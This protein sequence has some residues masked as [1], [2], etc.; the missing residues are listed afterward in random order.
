MMRASRIAW[1]LRLAVLS[2]LLGGT[3]LLLYWNRIGDPRF[4]RFLE[5][6]AGRWM[7]GTF[8]W[9]GAEAPFIPDERDES[10]MTPEEIATLR[11]MEERVRAEQ[12]THE[13]LFTDGQALQGRVIEERPQE[14]VFV[15]TYGD[16][17]EVTAVIPRRRL[18]S[19]RRLEPPAPSISY[20]DVR[21]QMEF[22]DL[23]YYRRPPYSLLTDESFFR[24]EETVEIL[25]VLHEQFVGIWRGLMEEA[26][27]DRSIQVLFF[28]RQDAFRAYQRQHAPRMESSAGFYS[29]RLDRL[30][31]F[32]QRG[33]ERVAE[34]R[35]QVEE[36][37][38]RHRAGRLA[39]EVEARLREWRRQT[40]QDIEQLA[41]N[42]TRATIRHEGAH[43]LFY[44][45]GIHSRHGV[46]GEWLIEGMATYC[47]HSPIGAADPTRLNSLRQAL[48]EGRLIG[49]EELVNLRDESGLLSFGVEERIGLAYDQAWGLVHFLMQPERRNAFFG[50]LRYLRDPGAFREIRKTGPL[51]L[52]C[53]FL[54]MAPDEL[55]QQW[56]EYILQKPS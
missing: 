51:A 4:Y 40:D 19:I 30:V 49:F 13:L 29:P 31:L 20:R 1:F 45:F 35:R 44:D 34:L 8:R 5:T 10:R 26:R 7:A 52:L 42:Q 27:P 23:N 53:R 9:Y 33:S 14:V 21:F 15:R 6:D 50:Y 55:W 47:E 25:E 11:R 38:A 16:S 28:S 22:P 43:Q 36:E 41:E 56:L 18:E 37:E 39:P 17:A 46:E 48:E 3:L 2:G 24:V 12:P 54:E 32:N